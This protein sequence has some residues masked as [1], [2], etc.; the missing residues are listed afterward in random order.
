MRGRGRRFALVALL[1]A[2]AGLLLAPVVAAEGERDTGGFNEFMLKGSNG[3]TVVVLATSRPGFRHGQ[4]LIFVARKGRYAN[5]LAPA[6]VTDTRID[7]D[8]GPLGEI[9]VTFQPSGRMG[10]AH[11][12][13][14]R[15]NRIGYEKGTYVGKIEFRGEEGY[16]R[17]TV[18]RAPFSF[19]P[20]IDLGCSSAAFGEEFGP[21]LP[22]AQLKAIHRQ[23][24][25]MVGIQVDQSHPGARVRVTAGTVERRGSVVAIRAIEA[26]YGPG[27][28][29][30]AAGLSS[31]RFAPPS[32]F[33]GVGHY[34][35]AAKPANRWTGNLT[36]DFP[37]H[38]N[39][40]LTGAR[41]RSALRHARFTSKTFTA[42]RPELSERKMFG[43]IAFMLAGNMAV[44]VTG[45]DLM[46][47]LDPA[48]HASSLPPRT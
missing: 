5:Y 22:G 21:D 34:H 48:D 45:E 11:P 42:A 10:V 24:R 20:A 28:F 7:A 39:V 14:E 30:V 3:Y 40:S 25:E 8:I 32:P 4:V 23:G 38:S 27:S 26:T 43:G 12:V 31:A 9:D 41:F 46:V 1:W 6:H 19:H 35:G 15:R 2:A 29:Q 13:C 16:T 17:V 44:G 37:G 36:I 33:S 47:R 18:D